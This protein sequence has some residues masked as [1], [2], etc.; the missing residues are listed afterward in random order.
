MI[1]PAKRTEM[2]AVEPSRP[3]D[4]EPIGAVTRSVGVFGDA[5]V[6]TVF[7]LF[8]HYVRDPNYGYNFLSYREDGRVLGFACW[9]PTS[10]T[11]GT[12]DLFWICAEQGARGRGVGEALFK[13]V[14]AGVRACGGRLIIIWTSGTPAYDAA[15]RFYARMGCE[16]AA[17]IRDFYKPGDDLVIFARYL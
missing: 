10:L 6:N 7:E 5:E 15:R 9:G 4:R 17:R 16:Q 1:R 11:D 14:E 2:G 8:D 3:G 12:H 13:R